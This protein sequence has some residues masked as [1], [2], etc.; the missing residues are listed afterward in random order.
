MLLK[1][2][3]A[4]VL[5]RNG[6]DWSDRYPSI[7]RA[8]SGLRC[9]SAII[10]GEAIIEDENGASDFEAL[11]TALWSRPDSIILAAFDLMH[12]DGTD[13]RHN[14]SSA[15]LDLEGA[16]RRGS[17]KAP[18]SSVK[19]SSVTVPNSLG[20]VRTMGLRASF[21]NKHSPPIALAAARLGSS[22]R[23]SPSSC[24]LW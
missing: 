9:R 7:V 22:V 18:F 15:P 6:H 21:P 16:N 17:R 10:D 23:A 20:D 13:L 1:R 11:S 5:T 19:S 12:L 8:A 4:R 24:L 2:G 3:Q 14:R